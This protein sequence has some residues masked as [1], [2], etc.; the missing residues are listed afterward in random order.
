MVDVAMHDPRAPRPP[1]RR[2]VRPRRGVLRR[3]SCGVVRSSR[4]VVSHGAVTGLSSPSSR[5]PRRAA[6]ENFAEMQ[7]EN[8]PDKKM[9]RAYYIHRRCCLVTSTC[10]THCARMSRRHEITSSQDTAQL[11][12]G[13]ST[14]LRTQDRIAHKERRPPPLSLPLRTPHRSPSFS[15]TVARAR[16]ATVKPKA[17]TAAWPP[18]ASATSTLCGAAARRAD[19]PPIVL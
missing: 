3:G 19:T 10:S 9:W 13:Y 14:P 17:P 16:S 5:R 4:R 1:D 18:P 7:N 11:C 6:G 2:A 8:A 12:A 15:R